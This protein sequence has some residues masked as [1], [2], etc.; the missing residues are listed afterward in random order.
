MRALFWTTTF[1]PDIDGVSVF[2]Y[3]LIRGLQSRGV[4][5]LV[6]AQRTHTSMPDETIC[7]G[8]RV[9]RCSFYAALLAHDVRQIA[10]LVR[11][12]ARLKREFQPD[13][14]HI[15]TGHGDLFFHQQTRDAWDCP[16]LVSSHN[17]P[18]T[19]ERN[20]LYGRVLHSA[21]WVNGVSQATLDEV[22]RLMPEITPR[23]SVILNG[24]DAPDLAP[25]PIDWE[26]PRLL[27]FGRVTDEKGF[28]LAVR[29]FADI[30]QR[31]PA[32]RLR[33]AGDGEARPRLEALADS[34]GVRDAIE[35]LGWV[36]PQRIPALLNECSLVLMPS[37]SEAFGIA[38]VQAAHMARPIIAAAVGGLPEV[39]AD[40]ETGFLVAPEQPAPIAERALHL[41][42]HPQQGDAMGKAARERAL[43]RFS[44]GRVVE[45]YHQ[46]Y[47]MLTS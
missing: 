33:I 31:Y 38:A 5:F 20:S 12:V 35:F 22:R 41:L 11:T 37:R 46:V 15:N 27:C 30:R 24:L 42:A 40:G 43:T 36:Q 45:E 17:S 23:S 19:N 13:L 26:A 28:D 1:K 6:V 8:V 29:A 44:L 32:A 9:R 10:A 3:P 2:T 18:Y 34:L 4:E 47:R 7:D 16:V 21:G 14:I 25:A 39:V